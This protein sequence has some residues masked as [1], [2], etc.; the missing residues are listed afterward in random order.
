MITSICG[1]IVLR[2]PIHNYDAQG[3]GAFLS[4]SPCIGDICYGGVD[5]MPWFDLYEDFYL[6]TL[7][8]DF[9][10]LKCKIENTNSDFSEIMTLANIEEAER[11]LKYSNRVE[12]RNE[13]GIVSSK[14]LSKAKGVIN[15]DCNILWMGVDIY[16]PGYGSQ[17]REGLF[18]KPD[19][20]PSFAKKLNHYGL[21]DE[22][23]RLLNSYIQA[24]MEIS[25]LHN[26]ENIDNL[27]GTIDVI[28]VGRLISPQDP[29]LSLR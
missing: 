15:V 8:A 16:C 21:F 17:I 14:G 24:Y 23:A 9:F 29:S 28:S 26:L 2:K 27:S 19:L 10:D 20:F 1:F 18:R 22:N 5:R 12:D 6:G 7:P 13:I 11:I 3:R 4:S 25:K